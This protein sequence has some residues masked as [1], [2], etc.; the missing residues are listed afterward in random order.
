MLE[1]TMHL[2]GQVAIDTLAIPVCEDADIHDSPVIQ[3]LVSKAVSLEEFSGKARESLTLYDLPETDIHRAVFF[4]LGKQADIKT[5]DLRI[6]S[7]KIVNKCISAGLDQ[8][9]LVVPT[10]RWVGLE[11]AMV[12]R[13]MAEGAVLAN[14]VFDYYKD[15]RDKKPLKKIRL[16]VKPTDY[17]LYGDMMSQIVRICRATHLARNWVNIPANDK[18]PEHFAEI[19]MEAGNKA[20][21]KT[22]LL[23]TLRLERMGCGAILAV[24]GGSQ[25]PARMVVMEHFPNRKSAAT[26]VLVGKGV[27]FDSGGLHLKGSQNLQ[28]MKA[29]MAGAATVAATMTVLPGME[30]GLNVVGIMPLVENMPSGTALRTGDVI[31]TF[32]GKSVEVANTDAEG[33][34]ILADAI[35]Y[36]LK[37]YDP[38]VII[39]LATL[40]GACVV[41]LGEKMAAVFTHDRELEKAIFQAGQDT[42]E[43]CWPMPL[44]E[45]YKEYLKSNIADICNLPSTRYGGAITAALFLKEFAGNSSW[46]HIDIAG[47]AFA[48]KG[49]AYCGPGGTGFGVRLLWQVLKKLAVS[50]G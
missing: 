16:L 12:V 9:E 18:R 20:G 33:R 42:F 21:L 11:P 6:F 34:L 36:G 14:H 29:D 17:Q 35:G 19:L 25:S 4:G 49:S 39:D 41:A 45:D 40:T 13:T 8:V 44:P 30:L 47:P 43:R 23:D 22:R 48:K 32:S 38:V 2:P 1:L 7:G 24:A 50:L 3:Q 46:A 5:E 37:T 28:G 15:L 27:T 10:P 26:V 31:R